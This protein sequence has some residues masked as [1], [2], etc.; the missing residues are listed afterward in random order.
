MIPFKS[1]LFSFSLL[2]LFNVKMQ[3]QG[4]GQGM[5]GGQR[6][7]NNKTPDSLQK[8]DKNADSIT[9]YF[10]YY[11]KTEIQKLDS[12][13]NDFF[14]HYPVP[15]TS[16][17]LGNLGTAS[18]SYLFNANKTIGWDAGFHSFDTY[19]YTLDGTPFYQTTRPY[20]EFGYLLGS[21]G[22][23]LIEIKH[24]QNKQQKLNFSFE[25]R[26]SNAP[27]NVKNQN[28]NVNNMRITGH[29]QSKR[30][31]YESFL[32]MLFNK[33]ASSENG[34]LINA[35]L[36]DSLALNDP[37]ELNTRLGVSG[38]SFRNPFNTNI[39]T[40]TT[41]SQ[42]TIAWKNSYDFGQK[43][44]I[45]K[46][47]VVIHLF[48]PRL[49]LQNEVKLLTNQFSFGDASPS[50][51]NYL[52]YFGAVFD[53]IDTLKFTDKWN[54]LSNEFSLI[55]YPEKMNSNQFLQLGSGYTQ[56]TASFLGKKGWNSYDIY[57]FAV[58]KNKTRNQL[59][60]LNANGKLFLNGFHAGD[61]NAQVS[62]SRTL[63]KKGTYLQVSFQNLNRTPSFNTLGY[64]QFPIKGLA[65]INK[66]NTTILNGVFANKQKGWEAA[67]TY[68]MIQNYNYFSAGFQP[69]VYG[70]LMSYLSGQVE[71]KVKISKHWN[72]Y[73]QA[74]IQLLD[75]NA[76]I[77]V[78]LLLTRQRI[79]FEGNFYK[80]LDLSTGLELIYHSNYK[81]DAYMPFTGQFFMQ[82]TYTTQNRPTA[83]AF[84]H[85]MIKRFKGYIR[86]ENLNTLVSTSK[87]LGKAYNFT[88]QNYPGTG[89]WFRV[90]IWWNFI[91]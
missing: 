2:L 75:P 70:N 32:V 15:Y 84:L 21:K 10:K 45:V 60:D 16:Y 76:P 38:A 51:A 47:T 34:G 17:N 80:N 82:N 18:K 53:K 41:Y 37:Y 61:Y 30:K 4:Y 25:Y 87:T 54:V 13:V 11:N 12:S 33:T 91:N 86:L 67:V 77:H 74:S 22:E 56:M 59:W 24:T 48:Y 20:T 66:E 23:Q 46:D 43:D 65:T 3:A 90:G 35:N 55:S 14:V 44:S 68:Q 8:R 9:I 81:A 85:F 5:N 72:W 89:M 27:G 28:S 88:V 78:P 40:G 7:T 29:Y 19:L 49:R 83:N 58:Y 57:G 31:R 63:S 6:V 73:D 69:A 1:I 62:L 79:A 26:F 42:N 64:T 50:A 36:L 52:Q 39:A 71:H